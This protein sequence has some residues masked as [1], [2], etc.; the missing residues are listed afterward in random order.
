MQARPARPT[1]WAR[2]PQR[3]VRDEGSVRDRLGDARQVLEHGEARA[4]VQVADLRVAHLA[5]RKANGSARQPRGARWPCGIRRPCQVGM[6]AASSGVP[7]GRRSARIHPA[8]TAPRARW[9]C[10]LCRH[11]RLSRGAQP[12]RRQSSRSRPRR[13]RRRRPGLHRCR[14]R[15]KNSPGVVGVTLPP[16]RMATSSAPAGSSSVR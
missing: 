14:A 10:L 13:V 9:P 16:Y 12:R 1:A 15:A 8:R 2:R 4:E 11:W 3:R 7:P 6:S 5:R